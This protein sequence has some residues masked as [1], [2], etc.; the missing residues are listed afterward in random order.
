MWRVLLYGFI[1][2]LIA[3]SGGES[4]IICAAALLFGGL[5]GFIEELK[6]LKE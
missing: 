5:C 1:M 4:D 2:Y 6:K 3:L